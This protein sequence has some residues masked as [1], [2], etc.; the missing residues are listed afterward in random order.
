MST[1]GMIA[2]ELPNDEYKAVYTHWDSYPQHHGVILL[3]HYKDRK[4]VEKLIRMGSICVLGFD[5]GKKHDF[6][7]VDANYSKNGCTFFRR[8]GGQKG[9]S[10]IRYKN[11]KELIKN[12]SF[13]WACY[14]Y[15]F[16]LDN[17]WRWFSMY[18]DKKLSLKLLTK[19]DCK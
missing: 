13:C 12:A 15:I 14:V 19:K 11:V 18:G 5:I 16:G 4:K 2:I 7:S 8:D 1:R 6:D 10:A 9:V 3:K 17:K